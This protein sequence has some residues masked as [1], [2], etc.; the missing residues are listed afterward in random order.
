MVSGLGGKKVEEGKEYSR[1]GTASFMTMGQT[2]MESSN[3]DT[4]LVPGKGQI[5]C[6]NVEMAVSE[7]SW[8]KGTPVSE[9]WCLTC[10]G[11]RETRQC[12]A[13]S[14]EKDKE[15]PKDGM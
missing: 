14:T 8:L 3:R 2:R 4:G 15:D 1:K 7:Q 9:Y 5:A 12:K 6:T 10:P 13:L 11:W